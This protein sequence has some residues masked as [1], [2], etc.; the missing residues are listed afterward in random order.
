M[1]GDSPISY[2]GLSAVRRADTNATRNCLRVI[3][4]ASLRPRF[5]EPQ[6]SMNLT[7]EPS[8]SN[9]KY[10]PVIKA[11]AFVITGDRP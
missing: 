10:Q 11:T 7:V 1:V 2:V 9:R 8:C 6:T 4:K 3:N 5:R